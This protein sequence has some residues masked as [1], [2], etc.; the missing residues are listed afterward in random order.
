MVIQ[1]DTREK[2]QAIEKIIKEF[3]RQ[4][5]TYIRSKLYAGDYINMEKP[6]LI[7][8]R[9]QTIREWASN[10]T[11]DHDRVKRELE[12]LKEIG[13]RMIFLIEED[14]IDG[15]PIESLEDLMLWEPQKGQG[16]ISGLKIYRVSR[17]W[18]ANYPI[19]IEFCNRNRTGARIIELLRGDADV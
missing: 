8:D 1:I 14:K 12:K 2:P 15:K 3:E 9:K 11:K 18:L 16:T 6:L 17:A 10:C 13:A 19:Q 4:H 5:I 7:I